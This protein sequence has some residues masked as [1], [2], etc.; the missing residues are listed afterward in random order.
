MNASIFFTAGPPEAATAI[1]VTVGVTGCGV[2]GPLSKIA[3]GA[4][5][6]RSRVRIVTWG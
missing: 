3:A 6:K 4:Y 5:S 2:F 1:D